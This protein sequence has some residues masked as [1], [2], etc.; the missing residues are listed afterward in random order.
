MCHLQHAC[1]PSSPA[2]A[3]CRPSLPRGWGTGRLRLK[4]F[5]CAYLG[6]AP[7]E[8]ERRAEIA[9]FCTG[10]LRHLREAPT[11][12]LAGCLGSRRRGRSKMVMIIEVRQIWGANG[13]A[14]QCRRSAEAASELLAARL[15]E[16]GASVRPR[17]DFRSLGALRGETDQA[18][19]GGRSRRACC[20]KQLARPR[21]FHI[22]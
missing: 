11:L 13:P 3:R 21:L 1:Q 18:G 7:G 22:R 12:S 6:L 4:H 9:G 2:R 8:A 20:A 10:R 19:T 5:A 16:L 17:T 14:E 15:G